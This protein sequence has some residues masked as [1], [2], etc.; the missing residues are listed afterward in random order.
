MVIAESLLQ[1]GQGSFEVLASLIVPVL[2]IPGGVVFGLR[3]ELLMITNKNVN[4]SAAH[5]VS[6]RSLTRTFAL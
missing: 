4:K 5:P 1:A 6:F 2:T 3:K